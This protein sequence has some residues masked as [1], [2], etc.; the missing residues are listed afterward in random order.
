MENQQLTEQ[1]LEELTWLM[2]ATLENPWYGLLAYIAIVILALIVFNLGFARELPVL[3]K[4][5]VYI[6]LIIGCFVLWMMEFAFGAPIIVILIVS[7]VV[8]GI[9]RFR[10]HLHRKQKEQA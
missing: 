5:I 3:K 1:E 7:G 9:Y 4:V 8:L 6:T 2:R 10:L